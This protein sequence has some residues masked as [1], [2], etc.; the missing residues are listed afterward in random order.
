MELSD[1]Y[2]T[3]ASLLNPHTGAKIAHT[4]SKCFVGK[5]VCA[6]LKE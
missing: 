1:V 6:V 2:D 5:N 4:N 3:Q